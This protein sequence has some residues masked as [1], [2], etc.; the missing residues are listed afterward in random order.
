MFCLL[1][2]SV[3]HMPSWCPQKLEVSVRSPGI[4]VMDDC[5]LLY[6]FCEPNPGLLQEQQ[7][8][9]AAEPS[10]HSSH[11]FSFKI[12][13]HM[14]LCVRACKRVLEDRGGHVHT[15]AHIFHSEDNLQESVLSPPCG[16][17]ESNPR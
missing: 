11:I 10:L 3:H 9:S 7:V 5:Q 13:S 8:L 15:T 6:G 1:C 12:L 16:F 2:I 4:G 17:H 14:C